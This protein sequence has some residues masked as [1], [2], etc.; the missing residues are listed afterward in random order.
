MLAGNLLR[1]AARQLVREPAVSGLLDSAV[2]QLGKADITYERLANTLTVQQEPDQA[3]QL[4]DAIEVLREAIGA[5]PHEDHRNFD[6]KGLSGAVAENGFQVSGWP[7]QV[8]FAFRSLLGYLLQQRPPK[9][10]I[11]VR[12]AHQKNGGLTIRFS[13]YA[14]AA[15]ADPELPTDQIAAAEL[16]AREVAELSR[17][18]IRAVIHRHNGE[19]S[20]RTN[21]PTLSFSI[22]L[23]AFSAVEDD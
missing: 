3:R 12:L 9:E 23:P 13:L 16:R 15:A 19:F 14:E 17:D 22:T 1:G 8:A 18:A 2:R 6:L 21:G 10:K 4:F 20:T 11:H 7:E 5:L